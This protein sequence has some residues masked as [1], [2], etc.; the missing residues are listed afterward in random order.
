MLHYNL[1]ETKLNKKH[2]KV[3]HLQG[4][5]TEE[6]FEIMKVKIHNLITL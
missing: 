4:E 2:K 3:S 6:K 1:C 5:K